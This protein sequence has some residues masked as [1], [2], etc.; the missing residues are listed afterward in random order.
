MTVK[1]TLIDAPKVDAIKFPSPRR[2][3]KVRATD[4]ITDPKMATAFLVEAQT[5]LDACNKTKQ[6]DGFE[7]FRKAYAKA[8][9]VAIEFI[10]EITK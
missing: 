4:D 3:W 6:S 5:V 7:L 9:V 8:E 10:G 2:I 1:G